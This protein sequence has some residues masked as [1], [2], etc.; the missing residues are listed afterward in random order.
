[1]TDRGPWIRTFTGRRFYPLDPR[2]E[3][4]CA[5]DIAHALSMQ[6][7]YAGHSRWHYSVAQHSVLVSEQVEK[8]QRN[9]DWPLGNS[10]RKQM[11]ALLHDAAEAYVL[12]IPRPLKQAMP[13]IQQAE[14][15]VMAA[16]CDAFEL[17]HEEPAIVKRIDT[18]I[19]ADEAKVL[20]GDPQ[21]WNLPEPA[22]GVFINKWKPDE[23]EFM[24]LKRF[25][26]LGGVL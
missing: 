19:L 11:W 22:L 1:V 26:D 14:K 3:D 6:C 17:P 15:K 7:R 2:P 12:D 9:S 4:V 5:V 13:E 23:A 16:I 18:A 10:R 21:D 24:W 25:M 8:W 20:M